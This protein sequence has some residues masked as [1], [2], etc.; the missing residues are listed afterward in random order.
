MR[1]SLSHVSVANYTNSSDAVTII[2]GQKCSD[3]RWCFV[4]LLFKQHIFISL[5]SPC[6]GLVNYLRH[7]LNNSRE[8]G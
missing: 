4:L 3:S 5:K 8:S 7:L 2:K 1:S 6:K